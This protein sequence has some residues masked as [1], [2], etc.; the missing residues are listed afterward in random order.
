MIK[1]LF[2][3]DDPQ[4]SDNI[5]RWLAQQGYDCVV[6]KSREEARE[7]QAQQLFDAV[8]YGHD[9]TI[10]RWQRSP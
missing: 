2:V 5:Q 4:N 1:I 8:L 7:L 6:A 3:N 10:G 9:L